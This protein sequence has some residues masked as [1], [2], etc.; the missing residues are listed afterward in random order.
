MSE[1]KC[2]LKTV[3]FSCCCCSF[4][5]SSLSSFF[6]SFNL[7]PSLPSLV[8]SQENH[9]LQRSP[10]PSLFPFPLASTQLRPLAELL[11][12]SSSLF[13]VDLVFRPSSTFFSFLLLLLLQKEEPSSSS[14]LEP[15]S[16]SIFLTFSSLCLSFS[17]REELV[18][19]RKGEA[20]S[21]LTSFPS[22]LSF[23]PFQ[24]SPSSSLHDYL[25]LRTLQWNFF[26]L[27]LLSSCRLPPRNLR[28]RRRQPLRTRILNPLLLSSRTP[29]EQQSR[30]LLRQQS[31]L[32]LYLLLENQLTLLRRLQ[33]TLLPP[34]RHPNRVEL[35]AP[36]DLNGQELTLRPRLERTQLQEEEEVETL[37]PGPSTEEERTSLEGTRREEEEEARPNPLLPSKEHPSS[38]MEKELLQPQ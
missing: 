20:P 23:H 25:R 6:F 30:C 33:R 35:R 31:F 11:R 7:P 37:R 15:Q 21:F 27:L 29:L 12:L 38:L 19:T 3:S 24:A 34:T 26:S 10:P 5:A 9:L 17:S 2:S 1:Q 16:V 13:V 14:K 4:S 18:E 36:P 22:F 8:S 32:R 28:R